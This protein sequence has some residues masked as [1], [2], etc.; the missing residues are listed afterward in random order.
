MYVQ[1]SH[2]G[3]VCNWTSNPNTDNILASKW[4]LSFR[5]QT[6]VH[7]PIKLHTFHRQQP[8]FSW[9]ISVNSKTNL[10][11][12]NKSISVNVHTEYCLTNYILMSAQE[13]HM[14]TFKLLSHG[15]CKSVLFPAE[16]FEMSFSC[17][18]CLHAVNGLT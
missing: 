13:L 6:T 16:D 12:P 11:S 7:L 2:T 4:L 18:R 8:V 3:Y 5:L 17:G 15:A 9:A 10:E 1:N 14:V